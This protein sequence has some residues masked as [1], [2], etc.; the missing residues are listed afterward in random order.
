[1]KAW[2]IC[3]QSLIFGS[4]IETR[5]AFIL[6]K[7]FMNFATQH[8]NCSPRTICYDLRRRSDCAI[9]VQGK[10]EPQGEREFLMDGAGVEVG[11]AGLISCGGCDRID[12]LT[13]R[14]P[15]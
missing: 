14:S 3:G 13:R 8:C 11:R 15:P 10:S 1:M 6:I 7:E 5:G 9:E 12:R 4:A 2:L